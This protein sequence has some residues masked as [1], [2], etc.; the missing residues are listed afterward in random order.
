MFAKHAWQ[1]AHLP[2]SCAK[3]MAGSRMDVIS[4]VTLAAVKAH[5]VGAHAAH[6]TNGFGPPLT[7]ALNED[8][9]FSLIV[10]TGNV[11]FG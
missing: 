4:L 2:F 10:Q 1:L 7:N 6:R 11:A 3:Q 5:N 9:N 8:A